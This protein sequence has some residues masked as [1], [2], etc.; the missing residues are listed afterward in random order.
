MGD[1]VEGW[2]IDPDVLDLI[3]PKTPHNFVFLNS[4]KY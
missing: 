1:L 4:C 3:T 2:A